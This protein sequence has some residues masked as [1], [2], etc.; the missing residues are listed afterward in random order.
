MEKWLIE[1]SL[2]VFREHKSILDGYE[3]MAA[4]HRSEI[5]RLEELFNDWGM[6]KGTPG[7]I[8][9]LLLGTMICVAQG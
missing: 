8:N 6:G 5:H 3:A 2:G 1:D 4:S 7:M 9:K